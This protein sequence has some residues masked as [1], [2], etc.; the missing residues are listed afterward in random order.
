MLLYAVR[1][2][3][4]FKQRK[5]AIEY[6]YSESIKIDKV[7]KIGEVNVEKIK[8]TPKYDPMHPIKSIFSELLSGTPEIKGVKLIKE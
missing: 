2:S 6:I 8:S 5:E 3:K 7:M 1:E 4:L